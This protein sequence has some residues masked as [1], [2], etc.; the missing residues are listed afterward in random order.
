VQF[1]HIGS[2]VRGD[3][4]QR[5]SNSIDRIS[6]ASYTAHEKGMT[7]RNLKPANVMPTPEGVGTISTPVSFNN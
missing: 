5:A 1:R 6:L 3:I 2:K 4:H 7:H